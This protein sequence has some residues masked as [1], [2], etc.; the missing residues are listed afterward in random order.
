M[1]PPLRAEKVRRPW[2]AR[3][4]AEVVPVSSNAQVSS[5]LAR[6][7]RECACAGWPGLDGFVPKAGNARRAWRNYLGYRSRVAARRS[8]GVVQ[9]VR[10]PPQPPRPS[11]SRYEIAVSRRSAL[12]VATAPLAWIK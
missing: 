9:A 11:F 5:Y 1:G 7:Y 8:G 12:C 6:V 10:A 2:R 4:P 3:P